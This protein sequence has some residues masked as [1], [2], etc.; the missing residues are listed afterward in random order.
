MKARIITTY[1]PQHVP[2]NLI[3]ALAENPVRLTG[4]FARFIRKLDERLEET[5]GLKI[6]FSAEGSE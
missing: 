2:E 6:V 5:T 1:P 3:P 4:E